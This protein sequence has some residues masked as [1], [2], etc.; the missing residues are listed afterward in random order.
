MPRKKPYINWT[1]QELYEHLTRQ[2]KGIGL[3]EAYKHTLYLACFD[4]RW[5]PM[6]DFDGC[7][8]VQD[9]LHPFYPCFMHDYRCIVLGWSNEYD[10]KFRADLIKFGFPKWKANMYYLVVRMAFYTYYQFKK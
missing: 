2:L 3:F 6:Q 5:N 9:D 10:L 7:T 8:F 1:R 4:T